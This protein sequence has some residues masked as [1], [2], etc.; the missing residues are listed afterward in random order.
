[1]PGE[2]PGA[3]QIIASN[4]FGLAAMLEA[5]GAEVAAAADR[6]RQPRRR[7][8]ACFDLAQGADLIVTIGGASVGRS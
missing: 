2:E 4:A 5:A 6:A 1:M 3:D 8:A 7:S